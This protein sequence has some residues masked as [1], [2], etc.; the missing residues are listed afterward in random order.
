MR[1]RLLSTLA[2]VTAAALVAAT[3]PA[4]TAETAGITAS[5]TA[6]LPA[7]PPTPCVTFAADPGTQVDFGTV[8]FSTGASSTVG[9]ATGAT[10]PRLSNCS[11][12]REN[13]LI[14][15]AAAHNVCA[16]SCPLHTWTLGDSEAECPAL[17]SYQ[18]WYRTTNF[19]G[20]TFSRIGTTNGPLVSGSSNSFA[21]N[22]TGDLE[23]QIKM[24]CEKSDGAGEAF[25]LPV[26]VTAMIP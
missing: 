25:S 19:G 7:P 4:F 26:S 12:V 5:V 23:L 17:N 8:P 22:Q 18:L 24:P 21:P 16:T 13:L 2:V 10:H 3:A 20:S 14:A 1:V 9:L 15:G 6:Q 11:T